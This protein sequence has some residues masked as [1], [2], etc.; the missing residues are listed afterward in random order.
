MILEYVKYGPPVSA[1][2]WMCGRHL[3]P[4]NTPVG[5]SIMNRLDDWQHRSSK[6]FP[7]FRVGYRK[8]G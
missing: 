2:K 1:P 8:L 7:F 6:N 3:A 5:K 4:T